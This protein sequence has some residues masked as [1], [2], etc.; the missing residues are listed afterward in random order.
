MIAEIFN[1]VGVDLHIRC[2]VE[3]LNQSPGSIVHAHSG[4]DLKD[5]RIFH[6]FFWF[7]QLTFACS[8]RKNDNLSSHFSSS[9][10]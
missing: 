5:M 2:P 6:T 1:P 4:N 9:D 10:N 3:S 7:K 8:N